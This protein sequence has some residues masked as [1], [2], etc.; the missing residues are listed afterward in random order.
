MWLCGGVL[1]LASGLSI[2]ADVE[3]TVSEINEDEA[4]TVKSDKSYPQWANVR[5]RGVQMPV[6]TLYNVHTKETLPLFEITAIKPTLL[7]HFFRCRGFGK[8]IEM[9]PALV[10][11]I[12]AAAKEFE[13][14]RT[15]IISGYRSTKF[16]D[17]LAKKG[18]RVAAESR[19]MRG[20][21]VD[22]RFDT[23]DAVK[24]GKWLK[25]NFEGGVGT[26]KQDNFV[27]IDV[28]P[29]RSWWGH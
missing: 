16:N 8:T 25:T 28:G 1:F 2:A 20:Q 26:Y 24:L 7:Q 29:K 19:H 3:N 18:R 11:T 5:R 10:E 23:V 4:V 13:A 15:T 12:L 21:A 14:K 9:A 22:F 27:H 6:T 17:T